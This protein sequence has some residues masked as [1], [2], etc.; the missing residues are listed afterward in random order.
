MNWLCFR[1]RVPCGGRLCR[2]VLRVAYGI[3]PLLSHWQWESMTSTFS[4]HLRNACNKTSQRH[5]SN[6]AHGSN[7][8]ICSLDAFRWLGDTYLLTFQ[9][10]SQFQGFHACRLN[11]LLDKTKT[12]LSACE[13]HRPQTAEEVH[14]FLGSSQHLSRQTKYLLFISG[15]N[16]QE[17]MHL[18][19]GS[20]LNCSQGPFKA[21]DGRVEMFC[22]AGSFDHSIWTSQRAVRCQLMLTVNFTS[23]S[24]CDKTDPKP[25]S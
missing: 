1:F 20:S 24:H 25:A 6:Y 8:G 19:S 22:K 4:L 13:L 3:P 23:A 15:M 14:K 7:D 12:L 5:A 9:S 2:F 10:T 11:E 18:A 16:W 17:W 21:A